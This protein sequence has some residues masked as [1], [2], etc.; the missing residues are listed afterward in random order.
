MASKKSP[1]KNF[2]DRLF[3]EHG[4]FVV[5]THEELFGSETPK[6]DVLLTCSNKE[7]WTLEQRRMLPDGLRQGKATH[8]IMNMSYDQ[9]EDELPFIRIMV[10]G[11]LYRDSENLP[12]SDVLMVMVL[13]QAPK[14]EIMEELGFKP[15]K[16]PGIYRSAISIFENQIVMVL[17]QL[18]NT[19]PNAPFKCFSRSQKARQDAYNTLMMYDFPGYSPSVRGALAQIAALTEQEVDEFSVEMRDSLMA[20]MSEAG[21]SNE[22]PFADVSTNEMIAAVE[23]YLRKQL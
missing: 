15:T 17:D 6:V 23:E 9:V 8:I 7:G 2:F 18:S 3:D 22:E 16:R 10:C 12:E 13:T 21:A 14:P 4:N 19:L 11:I 20:S 1:K 5:Y